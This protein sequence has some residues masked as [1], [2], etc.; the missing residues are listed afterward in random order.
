MIVSSFRLPPTSNSLTG[1]GKTGRKVMKTRGHL[2]VTCF[3][4][5]PAKALNGILCETSEVETFRYLNLDLYVQFL[6]CRQTQPKH[7]KCLEH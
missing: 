2:H 6:A 1:L 7:Y 5:L 3:K 4:F